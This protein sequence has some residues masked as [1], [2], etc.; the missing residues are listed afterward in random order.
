M[1]QID[2]RDRD[3][4]AWLL[5]VRPYRTIDSKIDGAVLALHP[6]EPAKKK[7]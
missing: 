1:Q 4:R 2:V 3:G 7:R 5:R 6:A